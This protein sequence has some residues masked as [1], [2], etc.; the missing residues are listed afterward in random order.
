MQRSLN[1]TYKIISTF[2]VQNDRISK[3]VPCDNTQVNFYQ[4]NYV[5]FFLYSVIAHNLKPFY[6]VV[7]FTFFL[8]RRSMT[9]TKKIERFE[10]LQYNV[11][12][13][14]G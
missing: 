6:I 13:N 12:R 7:S 11:L 5:V 8:T 4:S 2:F 14:I 3:S 10:K 1:I 9:R